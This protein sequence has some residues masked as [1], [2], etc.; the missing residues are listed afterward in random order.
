MA[1]LC[2]EFY[3]KLEDPV[4]VGG[5]LPPLLGKHSELSIAC[6]VGF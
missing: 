5:F 3:V 2:R 6:F 4:N 1:E